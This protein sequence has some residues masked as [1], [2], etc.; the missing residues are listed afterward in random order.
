[1]VLP[2]S[3]PAQI[4]ARLRDT[5][6][7]QKALGRAFRWKKLL[8]SGEFATVSDLARYE[9][10]ASSYMTRILRL[11]LL[12]PDI[13]ETLLEGNAKRHPPLARLLEPF[14]SDWRDQ[15]KH[16]MMSPREQVC[17][18]LPYGIGESVRSSDSSRR[19]R[20][21]KL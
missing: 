3:L 18:S 17:A 19:A 6:T 16:F 12:A 20:Q 13:V 14:P 8:E 15:R 5:C 4:E 2:D 7:I 11:T 9:A 1:M 21:N 10:I